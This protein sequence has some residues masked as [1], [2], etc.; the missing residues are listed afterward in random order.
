MD[1]IR[2]G[3]V[4]QVGNMYHF[5]GIQFPIGVYGQ[6]CPL[7]SP[8]D[9]QS[10]GSLP[11]STCA[12]QRRRGGHGDGGHKGHALRQSDDRSG[13]RRLI[14]DDHEALDP[15]RG[16]DRS[17]A[18]SDRAF[19]SSGPWAGSGAGLRPSDSADPREQVLHVPRT[20]REPTQGRLATRPCRIRPRPSHRSGQPERECRHPADHEH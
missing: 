15:P 14:A 9:A 12:L 3:V 18:R 2:G 16:G 8:D 20:R 7:G 5:V 10:S 13:R 6:R 1:R 11:T 19:S 4:T 17:S